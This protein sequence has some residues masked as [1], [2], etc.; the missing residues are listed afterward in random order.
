MNRPLAGRLG[1][2]RER[3]SADRRVKPMRHLGNRLER[4]AGPKLEPEARASVVG[5]RT[6]GATVY[7]WHGGHTLRRMGI[8]SL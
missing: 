6:V 3:V 7:A 8:P 1:E 2:F 5:K 4:Q